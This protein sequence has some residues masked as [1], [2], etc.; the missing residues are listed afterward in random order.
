[1]SSRDVV[2]LQFVLQPPFPGAE[3]M[4]VEDV[5]LHYQ[6]AVGELAVQ[7]H[8]HQAGAFQSSWQEA[9]Q[10]QQQQQQVLQE[11]VVRPTPVQ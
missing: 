11:A 2:M 6:K 4:S 9:G 8:L 3:S 7:L 5:L 1:M 10:Q